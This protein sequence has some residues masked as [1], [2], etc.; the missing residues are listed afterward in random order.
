MIGSIT[1]QVSL[2][3]AG[4]FRRR[5]QE[6]LGSWIQWLMRTPLGADFEAYSKRENALEAEE[7]R[8]LD[9]DLLAV[10]EELRAAR[11]LRI[12]RIA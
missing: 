10:I 6:P 5:E 8:G 4:L 9:E 2:S 1:W 3:G 11:R 7:I 12:V